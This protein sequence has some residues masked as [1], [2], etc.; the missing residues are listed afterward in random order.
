MIEVENN[1]MRNTNKDAEVHLCDQQS[2]TIIP[3]DNSKLGEQ[4]QARQMASS[5]CTRQPKGP[6]DPESDLPCSCPRGAFADPPDKL[7]MPATDSNREALETWIKEYYKASA[8]NTCKRQYWPVTAGPPMKIHTN[9]NAA[10][11]YC[12]KPMKVP[13]HF[14][15]EVR[16][17]LEAD[18]KK[19]VLERVPVG[20]KDTWCSRMVIQP[21]K[22]G[23]ARR[24][25]DLSGLSRVGRHESHHTRSAA[26]IVR[27]VPAG[28]LK[29][30]LDCVD[31][32]HGVELAKEDRHKTT[33][34][35]EWGLFRYLR[36]PQGYL[37]SQS[38]QTRFWMRALENL[39]NMTM[40]RS[41]MIS[42]SGLTAWRIT[43]SEFAQ[44]CLTATRMGWCFRL[45][46]STLQEKL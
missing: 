26:E 39:W 43:S 27:T 24:T 20:E 37:S 2:Q 4:C 40:K 33:F 7:S 9:E 12:R 10:R 19:G 18:V 21:K 1:A 25:V 32:Y 3:P 45:R 28:K 38:T 15:E 46:S 23:R 30:T 29:S 42:S 34:A 16:A 44:S 13:L 8:F 11:I 6:C 31:G 35:T 14:R 41:L 22:N 36:V 17:G 5:A